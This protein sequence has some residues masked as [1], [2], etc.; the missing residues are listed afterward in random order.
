MYLREKIKYANLARLALEDSVEI[1]IDPQGGDS[2]K[3]R[4]KDLKKVFRKNPISLDD[5]KPFLIRL[6][7]D[8]ESQEYYISH[9]NKNDIEFGNC[10][11]I[12]KNDEWL[13]SLNKFPKE[14]RFCYVELR[15]IEARKFESAYLKEYFNEYTSEG[16]S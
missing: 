10:F 1:I 8:C 3:I 6:N 14:N 16:L 2:L 4:F 11:T 12:V 13:N 7:S 5:S 15:E 9:F